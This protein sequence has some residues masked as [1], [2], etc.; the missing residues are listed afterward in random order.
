[1]SPNL[2]R[3]FETRALTEG[4]IA[5]G[6]IVFADEIA[7]PRIRIFQG[8]ALGFGAM[9]PLGRTI[10]F[11]R[12]RAAR[13]FA[14]AG[15]DDQGWLVHEMMHLWQAARGIFLGGAK[16]KALGAKAYAYT[17]KPAALLAAYNIESQAE[18]ARHLF[19]ART[20]EGAK[21]APPRA[22]LE[23]IWLSR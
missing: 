3:N 9:V 20:G 13:D 23:E 1:M 18:I 11:S 12:W 6:R 2:M 19:L 15:R 17:P 14:H 7:W 16:L 10:I 8:P 4:E 22:W 5:L 21:E